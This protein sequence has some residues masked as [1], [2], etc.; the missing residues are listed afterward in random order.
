MLAG[1]FGPSTACGLWSSNAFIVEVAESGDWQCQS[2]LNLNPK[3]LIFT[4]PK[5]ANTQP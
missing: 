5:A 2:R 4:L 1:V 3:Y